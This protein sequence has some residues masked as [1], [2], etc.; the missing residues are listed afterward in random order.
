MD[1]VTVLL[2]EFAHG[3]GFES[4]TDESTGVQ[5]GTAPGFPSVFDFFLLDK[6]TG[7]HWPAMTN[8]ERQASA[9]NTTNLVWDGPQVTTDSNV[10][11]AGKDT[12]GH[13]LIY[14]PSTVESGSSVSHWDKTE[15]PNQ[16][17]EPNISNDLTHSVSVGTN[18][19]GFDLLFVERHRLVCRL[20]ATAAAIA[21]A[22]AITA[23][24]RQLR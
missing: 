11:T 21:D 5:P 6:T 1:L 17:M 4:F 22:D 7:K 3:L 20:C 15:S 8:A 9:I 2:H 16:L 12:S 14:A 10:L 19:P 18:R 24:E 13:P 23:A